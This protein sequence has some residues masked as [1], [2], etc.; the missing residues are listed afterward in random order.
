[1]IPIF[2][3]DKKIKIQEVFFVF[4]MPKIQVGPL[5]FPLDPH[6]HLEYSI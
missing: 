5:V 1:M 3:E 4:I 6:R 2:F